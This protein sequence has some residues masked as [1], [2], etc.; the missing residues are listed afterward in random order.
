MKCEQIRELLSAYIDDMLDADTRKEVEAHLGVCASCVR[1]E[2]AL[3]NTVRELNSLE[4]AGAPDDFL[5]N[6][7]QRIERRN[8]FERMMRPVFSSK[9]AAQLKLTGVLVTVILGIAV[10]KIFEPG[11]G[12]R[13]GFR[14]ITLQSEVSVPEPVSQSAED[15]STSIEA[16]KEDIGRI[17]SGKEQEKDTIAAVNTTVSSVESGEVH[18]GSVQPEEKIDM[19]AVFLLQQGDTFPQIRDR[20]D[21]LV[22]ES[23]GSTLAARI[24]NESGD[25]IFIVQIPASMLSVFEARI[26][27]FFPVDESFPAVNAAYTMLTIRL[28]FRAK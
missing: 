23:R 21:V 8:E 6:V 18:Q 26:K 7:R 5:R 19:D 10:Y 16:A 1:E 25:H 14:Q 12:L 27:E 22:A 15:D 28:R 13:P 11:M 4:K 24:D 2:K 17:E 9:V 3:R 20:M